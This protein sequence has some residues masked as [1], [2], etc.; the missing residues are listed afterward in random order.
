M[1]E[2]TIRDLFDAGGHYGH[3]PHC[4]NPQ[5]A[6]YIYGKHHGIHIIDLDKTLPMLKA[7]LAFVRQSAFDGSSILFVGTKRAAREAV[8]EHAARCGMPYVNHHW[9]GGTLTNY[10]TVQA[11]INRYKDMQAVIEGG[12]L[13]KLSKKDAQ[14]MRRRYLKL[15]RSFEGIK[16]MLR[17]PDA[18]FV[19]DVGYENIAVKEAVRLGIPVTAIVDT[20][21]STDGV[22]YVIPANDDSLDLVT[23]C[24][25]L[26]ADMIMEGVEARRQELPAEEASPPSAAEASPR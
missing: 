23:L 16:D 18:M 6:P 2:V 3:R 11:S 21:S 1:V 20:N 15:H 19:I 17:P 5:N 12:E 9:L 22:D 13:K 10:R 4:W 26:I 25:S 24:T 7:A 8:K 14:R